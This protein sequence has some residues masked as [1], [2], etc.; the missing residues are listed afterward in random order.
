MSNKKKKK[1]AP[2][3]KP[4]E[5]VKDKALEAEEKIPAGEEVVP[6]EEAPAEEQP[7]ERVSKPINDLLGDVVKAQKE[8]KM[9]APDNEED[10]EAEDTDEPKKSKDK[11]HT[12]VRQ[13][14]HGMMSTVLTIVFVAAVVLVNVI[15]TVLF[16][17]YPLTLDLTKEKKFSISDE[18]I[19]YVE[20]IDTE[21][22]ITIFSTE[23]DFTSLS[24]YT[25]QAVEVMKKYKQYND[26]I[27]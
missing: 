18:S 1:T 13:L 4:Q 24:D 7:A 20:K 6:E 25:R 12:N 16:E 9:E 17:R 22:M 11:K 14:K 19:E 21:V 26:L 3:A 10:G 8:G 5:A 23:E 27:D 15:A 2:A